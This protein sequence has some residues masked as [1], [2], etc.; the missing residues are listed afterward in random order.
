MTEGQET[1][2]NIYYLKLIIITFKFDYFHFI[3][4]SLASNTTI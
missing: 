1:K 4:Q 2:I 3:F